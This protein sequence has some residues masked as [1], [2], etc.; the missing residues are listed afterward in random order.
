MIDG[1]HVK[2]TRKE[3]SLQGQTPFAVYVLGFRDLPYQMRHLGLAKQEAIS[4][5]SLY[6]YPLTGRLLLSTTQF[7]CCDFYG[8]QIEAEEKIP[9]EDI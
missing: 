6:S 3:L 2:R 9:F 4:V 1:L 7:Q 8:T 5:H